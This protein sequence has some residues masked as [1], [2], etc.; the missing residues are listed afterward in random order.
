MSYWYYGSLIWALLSCLSMLY[1]TWSERKG[2][3][4]S[5]V[6]TPSQ[7]STSDW[8]MLIVLTVLWPAV[9]WFVIV[10]DIW[11][12]LVKERKLPTRNKGVTNEKETTQ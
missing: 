12:W 3:H 1:M 11:P 9:L 10:W 8:G 2:R 7:Y 4:G 6:Q 5:E